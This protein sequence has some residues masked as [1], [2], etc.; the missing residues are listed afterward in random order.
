MSSSMVFLHCGCIIAFLAT[1]GENFSYLKP[2]LV[3]G[4]WCHLN[5]LGAMSSSFWV[6]LCHHAHLSK[7]PAPVPEGNWTGID[8]E[9]AALAN[10][11][12]NEI[13]DGRKRAKL[14]INLQKKDYRV[15]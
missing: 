10:I 12:K 11:G 7:L 9:T 1:I 8:T 2:L 15:G 4:G 3:V 6:T 14:V 5:I 13:L